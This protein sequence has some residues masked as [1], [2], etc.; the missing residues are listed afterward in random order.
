[1]INRKF[2]IKVLPEIQ[3]ITCNSVNNILDEIKENYKLLRSNSYTLLNASLNCNLSKSTIYYNLIFYVE[4]S[5][6]Y[7][8]IVVSK[9]N[10]EGVE[11]YGHDIYRLIVASKY[12]NASFEKLRFLLD[13]IKDRNNKKVDL[14]KYYNY[15]F[16]FLDMLQFYFHL[17]LPFNHL[18]FYHLL[19]VRLFHL[20]LFP[21]IDHKNYIFFHKP[22][23]FRTYLYIHN[24]LLFLHYQS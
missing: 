13:R 8:L 5:I 18:L 9:L 2:D 21:I 7:Y 19:F 22:H 6:K 10:I 12:Y 16:Q 14:S 20:M 23:Y 1:M 11:R 4:I 15:V 3:D 17:Y 24:T